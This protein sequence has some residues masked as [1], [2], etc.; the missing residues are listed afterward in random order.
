MK[1]I[2]SALVGIVLLALT[3]WLSHVVGSQFESHDTAYAARMITSVVG[4][5][6]SGQI[7]FAVWVV[8]DERS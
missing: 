2:L 1:W 8:M 5:I 3:M 6:F 4:G 7:A